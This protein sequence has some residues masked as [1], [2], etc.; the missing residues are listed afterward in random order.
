[1]LFIITAIGR[2]GKDAEMRYAANGTAFSN[3]SVATDVGF[4]DKKKTI[5]L[6][7]TLFGKQAEN[8]TQYLTKGQVVHVQG[9]PSC[10]D[11]GQVRIWTDNSGQP[12]ADYEMVVRELK[13]LPGGPKRENDGAEAGSLQDEI[14]HGTQPANVSKYTPEPSNVPF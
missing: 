3:F 6:K 2:L 11:K 7:C 14:N 13:L 8:L 1:M 5:W 10:T 4:G 12:H 9:E